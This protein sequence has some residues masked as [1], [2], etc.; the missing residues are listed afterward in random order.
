MAS[1]ILPLG[2]QYNDTSKFWCYGQIW[3]PLLGKL[4]VKLDSEREET[5][6]HGTGK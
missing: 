5:Y 2:V 3:L 4:T 6:S 1:I